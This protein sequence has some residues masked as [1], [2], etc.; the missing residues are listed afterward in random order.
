MCISGSISGSTNVFVTLGMI[1][2]IFMYNQ[3]IYIYI[4]IFY[5]FIYLFRDFINENHFS[6]S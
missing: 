4:Y 5:L 6:T 2:I 1:F 3:F